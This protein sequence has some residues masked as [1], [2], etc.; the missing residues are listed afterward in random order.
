MRA[1]MEKI[2]I[3]LIMLQPELSPKA[4]Q[5]MDHDSFITSMYPLSVVTPFPKYGNCFGKWA[6]A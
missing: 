2:G 6:L 3:V 1:R 4:T 5:N